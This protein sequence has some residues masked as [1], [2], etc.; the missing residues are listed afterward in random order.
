MFFVTR[1]WF[2]LK[3]YPFSQD[4]VFHPGNCRLF[5]S[6]SQLHFS[7]P[8]R[9]RD[10][11]LLSGNKKCFPIFEMKIHAWRK[12]DKDKNEWKKRK[13]RRRINDKRMTENEKDDERKQIKKQEREKK[14]SKI[15]KVNVAPFFFFF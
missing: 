6:P 8:K 14:R 5:F 4:G 10:F 3:R 13:I 7:Y 2:H 9:K 1:N 15:R 11:E 12:C